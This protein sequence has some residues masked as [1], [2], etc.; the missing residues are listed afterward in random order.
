MIAFKA[1]GCLP[2]TPVLTLFYTLPSGTFKVYDVSLGGQ[3]LRHFIESSYVPLSTLSYQYFYT[4]TR[5]D[6][7]LK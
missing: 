5:L 7:Y 4:L 6:C 3:I 2:F 1:L